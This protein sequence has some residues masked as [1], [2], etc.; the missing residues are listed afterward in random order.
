MKFAK[1]KIFIIA[2]ITCLILSSTLVFARE[3]TT[4]GKSISYRSVIT[5]YKVT[6]GDTLWRISQTF[7]ISVEKLRN[8]N[9]LK[10]NIINV[11]KEL[12]IPNQYMVISDPA[13]SELIVEKG[14][15]LTETKI[16]YQPKIAKMKDSQPR[17]TV[18]AASLSRIYGE[19]DRYWLAKIIEAEAGI[20]SLKGKIAVGAVVLNRVEGGW[21]PNSIKGVIFQKYRGTYQFSPVG[22]GR[23]FAVKPSEDAYL[24]ADRAL[25]GEDPTHGALYFYNPSISKSRFFASKEAVAIIGN[26]QFFN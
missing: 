12:Q 15:L 23:I 7:G 24:A 6:R 21:F 18:K 19:N 4:D 25:A 10:G 1:K 3:I 9:G 16:A 5:N 2:T 11:G 22:D 8:V 20:E 17:Q 26:H 13:K 14:R